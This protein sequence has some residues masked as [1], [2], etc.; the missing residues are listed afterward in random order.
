MTRPISK[1]RVACGS[2]PSSKK[3]KRVGTGTSRLP[4]RRRGFASRTNTATGV[5]N[6]KWP[7]CPTRMLAA[8][9][10]CGIFFMMC[11]S[12]SKRRASRPPPLSPPLVE[13]IESSSVAV[14]FR[15]EEP[16]GISGGGGGDSDFVSCCCRCDGC[17]E[18]EVAAVEV[19]AVGEG[20]AIADGFGEGGGGDGCDSR[21]PPLF[22]DS[23]L[24]LFS[25]EGTLVLPA[26]FLDRR[27][28]A[29]GGPRAQV[30][31]EPAST[32]SS[33]PFVSPPAPTRAPNPLVP[34][35]GHS[36]SA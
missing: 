1:L 32:A 26:R 18:A 24:L 30:H 11:V 8:S 20:V 36:V 17:V 35:T 2:G 34:C 33:E 13:K 29:L 31:S 19:G 9:A 10:P 21:A 3:R 25:C 14:S 28:L 7:I 27:P 16:S 22:T 15:F 23:R 12:K 6:A 4:G 5:E